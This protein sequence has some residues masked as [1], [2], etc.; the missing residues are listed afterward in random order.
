VAGI[1][2]PLDGVKSSHAAVAAVVGL[3]SLAELQAASRAVTARAEA[4]SRPRFTV[5]DLGGRVLRDL[6]MLLM[7]VLL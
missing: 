4:P 1:S 6:S 7:I 3:A 2:D 5:L